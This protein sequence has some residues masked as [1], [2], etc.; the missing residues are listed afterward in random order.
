M[1]EFTPI[2]IPPHARRALYMHSAKEDKWQDHRGYQC[3]SSLCDDDSTNQNECVSIGS[4]AQAGQ[5]PPKL[6][7]LL[8]IP[9]SERSIHR[10]GDSCRRCRN[11]E[12]IL[13]SPSLCSSAQHRVRDGFKQPK[14]KQTIELVSIEFAKFQV[15]PKVVVFNV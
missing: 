10:Q 9:G 4:G 13:D 1:T 6:Q 8:A 11:S 14:R 7:E 5:R 12:H 15:L 2:P 3:M